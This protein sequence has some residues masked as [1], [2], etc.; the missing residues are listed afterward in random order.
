M[1]GDTWP[2]LKFVA[3]LVVAGEKERAKLVG[4]SVIACV[5]GVDTQSLDRQR[6]SMFNDVS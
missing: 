4:E 1:E 2:P 3:V 6:V 5:D